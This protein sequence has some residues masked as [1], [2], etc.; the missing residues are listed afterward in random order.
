MFGNFIGFSNFTN[1][2]SDET[3]L[4][5]R[6]PPA[7]A[8]RGSWWDGTVLPRSTLLYKNH[9]KSGLFGIFIGLSNFARLW[10]DATFLDALKNTF[11]IVIVSVPAV[12]A[13][14]LWVSSAIYRMKGPVRL[15]HRGSEQNQDDTAQGIFGVAQPI[16]TALNQA[17]PLG[18]PRSSSSW[19]KKSKGVPV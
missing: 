19:Q 16:D 17:Q 5:R 11:V 13:F 6:F 10:T 3:F 12:C 1:L 2:L 9:R 7:A 4:G 14:S 15:S 8:A 18:G